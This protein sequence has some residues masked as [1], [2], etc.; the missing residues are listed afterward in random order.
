MSVSAINNPIGSP[1]HREMETRATEMR[2]K[3]NARLSASDR[4]RMGGLVIYAASVL[5]FVIG[6]ALGAVVVLSAKAHA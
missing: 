5:A 6:C 4:Y 1:T 3:G 2:T